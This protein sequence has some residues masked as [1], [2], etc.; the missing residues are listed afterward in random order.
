MG[1]Y[2][3]K[4][5]K[6]K[7]RWFADRL[8][9]NT[10]RWLKMGAEL[11]AVEAQLKYLSGPRMPRGV[12][13]GENP[14]SGTLAVRSGTLR[15]AVGTRVT[16]SGKKIRAQVGVWGYPAGFYGRVHETGPHF[17]VP[18]SKPFLQ[19]YDR[20]RWWR[21]KL[22]MLPGRPWLRPAMRA[23][24]KEALQIVLDQLIAAWHAFHP[25]VGGWDPTEG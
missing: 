18:K 9:G 11:V 6:E 10:A 20:G 23:K 21:A 24:R 13:G 14:A 4:Q 19:F 2:T 15:R 1:S 7:L 8:P 16:V 3:L 22:V 5:Y 17:I 25:G 12:P